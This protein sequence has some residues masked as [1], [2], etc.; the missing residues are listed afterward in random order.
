MKT[1]QRL[2]VETL[3]LKIQTSII[4]NIFQNVT[5]YLSVQAAPGQ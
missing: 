3:K 2:A 4:H 1:D 5:P